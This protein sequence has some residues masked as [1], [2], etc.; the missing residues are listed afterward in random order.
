MDG[1]RRIQIPLCGQG[2]HIDFP[3]KNE[4]WI[5]SVVCNPTL[6]RTFRQGKKKCGPTSLVTVI[7][8]PAFQRNFYFD[9]TNRL[10]EFCVQD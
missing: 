3:V 1:N 5:P 6:T 9:M 8:N 7:I 2:K 10:L 4:T